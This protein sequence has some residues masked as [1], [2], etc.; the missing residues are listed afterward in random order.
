MLLPSLK[1]SLLTLPQREES[2]SADGRQSKVS[3]LGG[4]ALAGSFVAVSLMICFAYPTA[5]TN[6]AHSGLAL[7]WSGLAIFFIGLWDDFRPLN[8]RWK[9][10]IQ[11]LVSIGVYLQGVQIDSFNTPLVAAVHPLGHWSGLVTVLWLVALINLFSRINAINGLAGGIGFVLMGLLAFLG[12]GSGEGLQVL[13]ATGM[14][15]A[16]LGFLVYNLP[17]TRISMGNGGAGLVGFLVGNLSIMHH[18]SDASSAAMIVVALPLVG[19]ALTLGF[20]GWRPQRPVPSPRSS[21]A[22]RRMATA[23]AARTRTRS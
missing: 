7:L 5:W 1:R 23:V 17:P 9:I 2:P 16:L 11:I 21:P 19:V 18:E 22:H 20:I 13:C 10:L 14:A 6:E 3:R 15:G 4:V 8:A 12:V